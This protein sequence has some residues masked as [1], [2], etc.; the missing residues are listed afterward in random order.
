M[1]HLTRRQV[2][3]IALAGLSLRFARAADTDPSRM[4]VRSPAPTDL[5]MPLDGFTEAITPIQRFFVRCHTNVPHV[6]LKTWSLRIKEV[7]NRPLTLTMDD[8]RKLPRTELVSVLEC[9]GNGRAFYQ[10]RVD[11]AQWIYGGAGNGRWVGVRLR[12]VL[13]KAGVRAQRSKFFSTVQTLR[14][15]PWSTC[16]AA[17]PLRRRFIRIPCSFTK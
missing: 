16:G 2:L 10:P 4:I 15:E 7:V 13:Q 14:L 5:E 3:G 1:N 12:D 17:S 9:A 8:L 11:G 6:N